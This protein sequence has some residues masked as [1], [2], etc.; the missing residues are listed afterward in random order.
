MHKAIN[1]LSPCCTSMQ[2]QETNYLAVKYLVLTF[3]ARALWRRKG[4][5]TSAFTHLNGFIDQITRLPSSQAISGGS[6]PGLPR[7]STRGTHS[8]KQLISQ[9]S[10]A[11]QLD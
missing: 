4:I 8:Q 6:H 9:C 11:A 10:N 3:P 5:T 7:C 2:I 1:H